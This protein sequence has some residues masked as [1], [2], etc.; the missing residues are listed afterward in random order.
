L[1]KQTR[2]TG[3]APRDTGA[4]EWQFLKSLEEN[5]ATPAD[6]NLDAV[7]HAR[8]HDPRSTLKALAELK[9]CN[10]PALPT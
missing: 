6:K 8:D 3:V 9:C 10:F 5:K 2:M 4:K 7:R 1:E